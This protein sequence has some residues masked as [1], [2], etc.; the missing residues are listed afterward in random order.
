MPTP[1]IR[2]LLVEDSEV[3][4]KLFLSSF[5]DLEPS[6][7]VVGT[8]T[9]GQDG[10]D[11]AL[12]LQPDVIVTDIDMPVMNGVEFVRR[13]MLLKPT[14]VI[15]L[16]SWA[17]DDK[18]AMDQA[19]EAGAVD[20]ML[21]P[22]VLHPQGFRKAVQL[23]AAKIRAAVHLGSTEECLNLQ[24]YPTTTRFPETIL[25]LPP[26]QKPTISGC[27]VEIQAVYQHERCGNKRPPEIVVGIGEYAAL[28]EHGTVIKTFALGSCV[29]LVLYSPQADIVG[30]AHIALASSRANPEK[31]CMLPG[32]FADT[33]VPALI[34]Q[35]RGVG[36]Q[37]SLAQLHA[38]VVGGA[39][40]S[41]DVENHFKIGERNLAAVRS[42]VQSLHINIIAED[43][44]DAYSR[45]VYACVGSHA[46]YVV[47]PQRAAMTI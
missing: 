24:A 8:A 1:P 3:A 9:H 5:A 30:M 35:M 6:I 44:G 10:I 25:A 34:D 7:E 20:Y 31:A 18:S 28:N 2:L 12:M 36:Y 14:P 32:Y 23:L 42:I 37:C 13:I 41:A 26:E 29:A 22:S 39:K 4:R 46:L 33:A 11:K 21:K 19:K 27:A 47:S 38:K 45:T 43:V 15:V 16:S 17:H 40:T